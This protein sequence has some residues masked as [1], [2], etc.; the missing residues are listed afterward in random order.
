[1]N[2]RMKINTDSMSSS[3]SANEHNALNF[4]EKSTVPPCALSQSKI[5]NFTIKTNLE[6][7]KLI[8]QAI[9]VYF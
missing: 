4:S 2:K 6:Q 9:A 5:D 1:M 8:N 3:D 7:K